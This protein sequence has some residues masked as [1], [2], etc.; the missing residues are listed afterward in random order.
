MEAEDIQSDDE[1][2]GGL[3]QTPLLLID[4]RGKIEKDHCS[5]SFL[6]LIIHTLF[7]ARY[8]KP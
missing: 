6:K 2:H 8:I 4:C 1:Y 7:D 5:N 3:A